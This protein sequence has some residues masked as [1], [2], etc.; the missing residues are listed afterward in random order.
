MRYVKHPFPPPSW[1]ERVPLLEEGNICQ[2]TF[3]GPNETHCLVG[4]EIT[5]GLMDVSIGS[6]LG[7]S[8]S[9]IHFNDTNPPAVVAAK[10]NEWVASLGYTEPA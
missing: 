6:F 9:A 5:V 1:P 7:P 3:H 10:W 2:L 4:W 8:I